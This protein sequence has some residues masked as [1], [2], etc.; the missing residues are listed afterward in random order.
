MEQ[1]NPQKIHVVTRAA[2]LEEAKKQNY[3]L[4]DELIDT[5]MK[6]GM[7]A[8][9]LFPQFD[10]VIISLPT[11]TVTFK[12]GQTV[13]KVNIPKVSDGVSNISVCFQENILKAEFDIM[14]TKE[15]PDGA[16]VSVW[17]EVLEKQQLLDADVK[18]GNWIAFVKSHNTIL[19]I[20]SITDETPFVVTL[21]VPESVEEQTAEVGFERIYYKREGMQ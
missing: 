19:D 2:I 9:M 15:S 17:H 20:M 3:D 10:K 5:P 8:L 4:T 1:E 21:T 14:T 12:P 16:P 18:P 11:Y 6:E 13:M 7:L